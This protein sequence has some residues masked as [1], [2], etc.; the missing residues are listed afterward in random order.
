MPERVCPHCG[1]AVKDAQ[2]VCPSCGTP[3]GGVWPPPP[4]GQQNTPFVRLPEGANAV[5]SGFL[6][7]LTISS[8]WWVYGAQIVYA[9]SYSHPVRPLLLVDFLLFGLP[10][11]GLGTAAFLRRPKRPL[12]ARGLGYSALLMLAA[13]LGAF[14][15]CH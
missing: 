13:M 4:E 1:E 11:L 2:S 8:G 3:L 14:A 7:G 5:F 9:Q 15:V 10:G 12:F 6:L